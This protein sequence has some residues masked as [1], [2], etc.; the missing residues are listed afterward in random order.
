VYRFPKRAQARAFLYLIPYACRVALR[1]GSWRSAVQ[2]S[3]CFLSRSS[4]FETGFKIGSAVV[5][6]GAG[7][8]AAGRWPPFPAMPLLMMMFP[9]CGS[10][11]DLKSQLENQYV[12]QNASLS[13]LLSSESIYNR[14]QSVYTAMWGILRCK[15]RTVKQDQSA[16]SKLSHPTRETGD[17][18]S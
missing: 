16:N 2:G 13:F 1:C 12:H 10:H 7:W 14:T 9:G 18:H 6:R 15:V 5:G 4:W 3:F 11:V 8:L 17:S